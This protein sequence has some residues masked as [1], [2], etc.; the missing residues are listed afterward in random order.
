MKN[1]II[2]LSALFVI[3]ACSEGQWGWEKNGSSAPRQTAQPVKT[4]KTQSQTITNPQLKT[5]DAQV[6]TAPSSD[7]TGYH[8]GV[9]FINGQPRNDAPGSGV[10]I[11][12]HPAQEYQR[13]LKEQ[14]ACRFAWQCR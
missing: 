5:P 12:E 10:P 13:K 11:Y 2:P 1:Y 8:E 3:T 6:I 7:Y 4:Q 9:Y 14:R